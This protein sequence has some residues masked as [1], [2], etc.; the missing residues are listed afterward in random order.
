MN[1]GAN[2]QPTLI[3]FGCFNAWSL[4]NKTVG[5]LELLKDQNISICSVTETWLKT[6][7]KAKF[8]EIHDLGFDIISAPRRGRGGG[9]AFLYDPN[10][11]N[12][13]RND[14]KNFSSFEVLEC[15]I[16]TSDN[17]IRLC[18]IYRS[19]QATKKYQETKIA[20]F[21]DDFSEYLDSVV[22]KVGSPI[23]CG[24][25]NF[26]VEDTENKAAKEFISL[27]ASKGFI[28]HVKTKTHI[29]SVI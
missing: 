17:M 11:I 18:V 22:N 28:Q 1:Q 2:Q 10:V 5:V 13:V 15:V 27:C 20:K 29:S 19:T 23:I 25:F 24:D 8:S 6:N 3:N 14:V 12:P 7:D 9:V 16:K 4:C 26:H 21:M